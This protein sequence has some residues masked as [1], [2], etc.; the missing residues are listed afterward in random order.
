MTKVEKVTLTISPNNLLGKFMLPVLLNFG[1][2]G[3]ETRVSQGRIFPKAILL[4]PVFN[5]FG[6]KSLNLQPE[7]D[8][9]LIFVVTEARVKMEIH[10]LYVEIF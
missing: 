4:R 6:L 8:L 2:V 1:L 9:Q 3:S 7:K 5:P 10:E